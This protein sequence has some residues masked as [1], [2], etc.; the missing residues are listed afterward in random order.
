VEDCEKPLVLLSERVSDTP[1]LLAAELAA[2]VGVDIAGYAVDVR[3]GG[4]AE[5]PALPPPPPPPPLLP[6][7]LLLLLLLPAG[8]VMSADRDALRGEV[9]ADAEKLVPDESGSGSSG[10]IGDE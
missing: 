9:D 4:V 5:R 10:I 2:L 6:R 7:F 8:N 3:R 1:G